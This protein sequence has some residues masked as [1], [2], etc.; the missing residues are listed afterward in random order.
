MKEAG[1]FLM[2]L[3]VSLLALRHSFDLM[4]IAICQNLDLLNS[5]IATGFLQFFAVVL[6]IL[7]ILMT[8]KNHL[9]NQF[10]SLN[11]NLHHNLHLEN[12]LS[13]P[14]LFVD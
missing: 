14:K 12:H 1:F 8:P 6:V 9:Q 10:K 13:T 5:Y 3:M 4:K 11:S 2:F 7:K